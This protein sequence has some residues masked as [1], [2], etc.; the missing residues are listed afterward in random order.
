MKME[1]TGL[2]NPAFSRKYIFGETSYY[3]VVRNIAHC[4]E[5]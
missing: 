5:G 3:P 1:N 4:F 2:A